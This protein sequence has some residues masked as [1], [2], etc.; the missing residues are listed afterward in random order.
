[1]IEQQNGGDK[2]SNS[3]HPLNDWQK[4]VDASQLHTREWSDSHKHSK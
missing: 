2:V 4:A 3:Y 1:M